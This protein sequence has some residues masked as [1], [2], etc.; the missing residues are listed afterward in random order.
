MLIRRVALGYAALLGAASV[1][2]AS[3]DVRVPIGK[4]TNQY[5]INGETVYD[6][7]SGLTWKR[8]SVGLEWWEGRGCEGELEQMGWAEA[9]QQ[10]KDGWRLPTF[11]ELKTLVS[12][13]CRYPAINEE[14]F[15]DLEAG[16]YAYWSSSRSGPSAVWQV[17]FSEGR[18]YADEH[19]E[20]H[21]RSVRLVRSGR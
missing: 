7:K 10:G 9:A 1:V 13:T 20:T 11:E 3:C 14:V 16:K 8:C 17:S 12:P 6:Q 18:P 15:P 19:L 5:V 21:K 2:Q 4:S